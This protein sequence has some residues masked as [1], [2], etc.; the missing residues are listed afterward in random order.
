MGKL[1]TLNKNMPRD[2]AVNDLN[3]IISVLSETE[4]KQTE[5]K[6]TFNACLRDLSD[7]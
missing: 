2:A 5:L 1:E 4:D 3:V 7:R 6:K